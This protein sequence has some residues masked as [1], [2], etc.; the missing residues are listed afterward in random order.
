MSHTRL[1]TFRRRAVWYLQG[2]IVGIGVD[3]E[4]V[5]RIRGAI[6]RHGDRFV[7]RIFTPGEVAY[8]ED[9]AYRFAG[10]AVRFAAKEAAMKA[11]GTGW[12]HGV[13]WRDIEVANEAGGRPLLRLSGRAAEVAGDLGCRSIH[14]SLSHTRETAMAE[15]IFEG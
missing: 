2:M 1:G 9:K 11:L 6:E 13:R 10:Y 7:G 3:L 12:D 4:E 5:G 14:L 15:V 8:V